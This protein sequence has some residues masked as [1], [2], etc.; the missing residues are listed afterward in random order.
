MDANGHKIYVKIRVYLCLFVFI[1]G[2][3]YF[4]FGKLKIG[5]Y[6]QKTIQKVLRNRL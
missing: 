1:R 5:K 6:D 4:I 3:I 2:D